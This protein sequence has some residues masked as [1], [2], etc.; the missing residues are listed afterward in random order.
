MSSAIAVIFVTMAGV[1]PPALFYYFFK[2]AYVSCQ[3]S[4]LLGLSNPAP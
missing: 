2:T 3:S 1:P 4:P